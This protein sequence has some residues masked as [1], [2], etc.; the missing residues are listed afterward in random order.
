V[1]AVPPRGRAAGAAAGAPGM[2]VRP[3]AVLSRALRR[4]RDPSGR[5]PVLRGL[6]PGAVPHPRDPARPRR[7]PPRA[8]APARGAAAGHR[9]LHRSPGVAP[10]RRRAHGRG[11]RHPAPRAALVRS[12][13]GRARGGALGLAHRDHAAGP[14]PCLAG[15]PAELHAALGVQHERGRARALRGGHRP[16]PAAEDVRVRERVRAPR[17]LP[18]QPGLARAG[19]PP[20]HLHHRGAAVRLSAGSHRRD[21]RLPGRHRVRVARRR[22]HRQRVPGGL[23]AR[24]GRGHARRGGRRRRGRAG[25]DHRDEPLLAGHAHHPV[26]DGRPRAARARA[27]SLRARPAPPGQRGGPAHRLPR[28]GGRPAAARAVDHLHSPRHAGADPVP[29][30]AGGA[31]ARHD[32]DRPPGRARRGRP[33]RPDRARADAAGRLRPGRGGAGGR[34]PGGG[35]RHV[36]S[37]IADRY[38]GDLLGSRVNGSARR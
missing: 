9:R 6:P 21:V 12:G 24:A 4:A 25:R 27:V 30:R 38:V 31:R 23:A 22:S 33:T 2:G 36:V 29:R 26:P 32:T 37:R 10:D 18:R 5:D 8:R 14:R 16:P 35:L 20:G 17:R 19:D 34:D 13:A 7:R 15:S 28:R 11:R 1:D 3:R